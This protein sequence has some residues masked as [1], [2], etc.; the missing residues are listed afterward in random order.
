MLGYYLVVGSFPFWKH[1]YL[2]NDCTH[3]PYKLILLLQCDL[4]YILKMRVNKYQ[5]QNMADCNSGC[6][7]IYL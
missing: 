1:T 3:F 7:R 5:T 4:I 2:R 6:F